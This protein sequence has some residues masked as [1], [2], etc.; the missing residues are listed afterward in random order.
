MGTS[1]VRIQYPNKRK[2]AASP[3]G[4][5]EEKR[6]RRRWLQRLDARERTQVSILAIDPT[7]KRVVNAFAG[8]PRYSFAHTPRT[9]HSGTDYVPMRKLAE[10]LETS[11]FD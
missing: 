11:A 9:P 4:R 5:H 10:G 3:D 6:T 2:R 8:D 1:N 7:H